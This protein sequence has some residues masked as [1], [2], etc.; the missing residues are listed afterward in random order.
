MRKMT[1]LALLMAMTATPA[2]ADTLPEAMAAALE[3]NP[4]LAAARARLDATREAVPQAWSEALPQIALTAT[5]TVADDYPTPGVDSRSETWSGSAN[6]SQLL[7][8]SGRVFYSTRA[9]RAQVRAAVADY[10]GTEQQLLLDV[11]AA[12][13]DM[14]QAQAIVSARETTVSNLTTLFEY[15]QAQF[16]AG[17]VT[18]TDVAQAQARLAQAH[19]FL[20]Q[21]Q[22]QLAAAFEAYVRLVGRPPEALEAP[23]A[24]AGIPEALDGALDQAGRA[25]PLL[26][27][28]EATSE[29]ADASVGLAASQGRLRVTLEA[30]SAIFGDFEPADLET[31]NDSVGVRLAVPLFSG[32]AVRSQTRA[33]RALRSA[34]NL[35]LANAQRIVREQVTNAWTALAS[36]RAAVGSTREQVGAAEL[37]YEGIRLEQEAGSRS[38]IDVLN[39]EQDLL[40]ARLALAAAERDLVVAER[41]MLAAVGAL[42]PS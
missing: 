15:A 41:A 1:S 27:A 26:R 5:A 31:Q 9:A 34:A 4:S 37:A 21:A 32:G 16:D 28:A 7:F 13:A 3:G 17:V 18:K 11:A 10:D 23:A 20:I 39:Q 6:V 22:G 2:L 33:Q 8:G 19:T 12:Y 36:A 24:P 30:G 29:Q 42:E 35:D 38:T 40:D 14:R 25:S